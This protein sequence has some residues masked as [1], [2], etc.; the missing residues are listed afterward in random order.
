MM[1]ILYTESEFEWFFQSFIEAAL[2]SSSD[3]NS[4]G[5]ES[6]LKK[7]SIDDIDQA[8]ILKLEKDCHSFMT[9]NYSKIQNDLE[10]AG[11]DF[12]L[13]SNRHGAGFWDGDW[14]K[15]IG[16]ELTEE[17]HKYGERNFWVNDGIVYC[18]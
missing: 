5:D 10:R 2:W 11:H 12:W 18:D 3:I 9:N 6:L 14:E 13:T 4:E 17:A 7:Y 15:E 1:S 8:S 16:Q